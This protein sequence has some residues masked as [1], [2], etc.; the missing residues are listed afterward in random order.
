L[1][2]MTTTRDKNFGNDELMKISAMKYN[3]TI[4]K[5]K[6]IDFLVIHI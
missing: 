5:I 1:T 4:H 6:S 2:M 3:I